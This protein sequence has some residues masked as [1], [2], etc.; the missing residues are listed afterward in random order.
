[1]SLGLLKPGNIVP[2]RWMSKQE[3]K[4][5]ETIIPIDY[6]IDKFSRAAQSSK[7]KIGES[8]FLIKAGTGS[9]KSTLIPPRLFNASSGIQNKNIVV[10]QPRILTTVE[11]P[12]QIAQYNKE[13]KLGLNLGYQTGI[14][15]KKP[16]KGLLYV[17]IGVLY[18]YLV[19][20]DD[21]SIL[22]KY[23]AIFIDEVHDRS[24]QLDVVLYHLKQFLIRNIKDP[25]CPLVVLMSAT[26]EMKSLIDYFDIHKA[27]VIDVTGI[28]YPIEENFSKYAL[29]DY[30]TY[31]VDI[32]KKIHLG[33][34]KEK[35][36]DIIIF[37][38]GSRDSKKIGNLLHH[39]NFQIYNKEIADSAEY[40]K[41]IDESIET[42]RIGGNNLERQIGYIC[43]VIINSET[44]KSAGTD[45]K[46]LYTAI[47]NITIPIYDCFIGANGIEL[48]N[49]IK[50]VQPSRKAIITT[51]V[52]ETGV[53]LHSAKYCIDTG[54][55]KVNEY[56]PIYNCYIEV[57]KPLTASSAI[58]RK[59]RVGRTQNGIWYPCYNKDIYH[60]LVPNSL[61]KIIEE[62][63]NEAILSI[64]VKESGAY[65]ENLLSEEREKKGQ[66]PKFQKNK[67]DQLWYQFLVSR[68]P[69]LKS[70]QLMQ[71]PSADSLMSSVKILYGLGYINGDYTPT[72]FGYYASKIRKL[73]LE[74]IRMILAAYHHG[75][76]VIDIITIAAFIHASFKIRTNKYRF[77][78]PLNMK[79]SSD[80]F[81]KY[82]ISD[83]FIEFIFIW[84]EMSKIIDDT[85]GRKG[86]N[87]KAV[88]MKKIDD[89]MA[90]NGFLGHSIY[91][92][93]ELRDEIIANM[94]V[95]G[96]NPYYNGMNLSR[97]RYNLV[98][99]MKRNLEEGY[100]EI[101][102]I[103]HCIYE[104]YRY[105]V[106]LWNPVL[107][108][109][110][111]KN[112]NMPIFLDTKIYNYRDDPDNIPKVIAI[113][114]LSVKESSKK[115]G[116]YTFNGSTVASLD[117]IDYDIDF[118]EN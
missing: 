15:Q 5:I 94:L 70:M 117:D 105:N 91:E 63:I 95:V 47:F 44:Y 10:S 111:M 26:I 23:S 107:N 93:I 73:S 98:N 60:S 67:I 13:F 1:M 21:S 46:N 84:D 81:S 22:N 58:Q 116:I 68:P 32:T 100:E 99:M 35:N 4:E 52:A 12:F 66:M 11:I 54:Y 56:N 42:N 114:N 86:D 38:Q 82:V 101:K 69:T 102:K 19:T 2:Q 115:D 51:N 20:L 90:S 43:P 97:G 41:K 96:L 30:I 118:T 62:N 71:N 17:T 14:L 50:Y 6:I 36:S 74:N 88:L 27:N 106:A 75:A 45:Y 79:K 72:L 25:R 92:V 34:P 78:N 53:T 55:V 103:K 83:E 89:W 24:I 16:V 18:Q 104:G 85:A 28:S 37:V 87:I 8:V 48:G 57:N 59:G 40:L 65:I 39:F 61:P 49:V 31:A 77:R 108:N 110:I 3:R 33:T 109:Y 80:L 113:A 7:K 64:I 76:N 29:S 112:T 9:G